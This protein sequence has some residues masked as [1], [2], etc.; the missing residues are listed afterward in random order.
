MSR[1]R[2]FTVD[3]EFGR[4]E[5]RISAT[6]LAGLVRADSD[7]AWPGPLGP[8]M[9]S[10][11]S[12]RRSAVRGPRRSVV[13]GATA[14]SESAEIELFALKNASNVWAMGHRQC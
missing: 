13:T 12:R 9:M 11:R 4:A 7:R 14:W 1:K 5:M 3:N 6:R 2:P 8:V 10:P